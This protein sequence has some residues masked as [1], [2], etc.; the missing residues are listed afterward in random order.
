MKKTIDSTPD[1]DCKP[2]PEQNALVEAIREIT[3]Q[4]HLVHIATCPGKRGAK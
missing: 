4:G 1:K 2:T 3:K